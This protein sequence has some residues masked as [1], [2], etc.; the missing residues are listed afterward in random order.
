MKKLYYS[1]LSI[2]L[3]LSVLS[4]SKD[5]DETPVNPVP[6]PDLT[7][8]IQDGESI[9]NLGFYCLEVETDAPRGVWFEYYPKEKTIRDYG[10]MYFYIWLHGENSVSYW[11]AEEYATYDPLLKAYMRERTSF[12]IDACEEECTAK[13]EPLYWP[14]ELCSAYVDG[15]VTLTCDKTLWGEAPGTNLLS[16]FTVSQVC[17]AVGIDEPKLLSGLFDKKPES[18]EAWFQDEAWV[19]SKYPC[20]MKSEPSEKYDEITLTLTVPLTIEPLR[21]YVYYKYQGKELASRFTKQTFTSTC[22]VRFEW[23]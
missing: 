6:Q 11:K 12:L 21:K 19:Y 1:L 18:M 8:T 9:S 10:N 3:C 17:L 22:K 23:E 15:G 2:M 16:H 20:Y 5:S 7:G 14:D 4:C 13:G